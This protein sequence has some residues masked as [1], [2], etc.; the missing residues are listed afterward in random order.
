MYWNKQ[1]LQQQ[2]KPIFSLSLAIKI[3]CQ[4]LFNFH[5][6][7][8]INVV[9]PLKLKSNSA[10]EALTRLI[11]NLTFSIPNIAIPPVKVPLLGM[12]N[13]SLDHFSCTDTTI[14]TIELL[15]KKIHK[16]IS[17]L[18]NF[19]YLVLGLLVKANGHIRKKN[20]HI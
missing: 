17:I 3:V 4:F 5:A 6:F 11:H 8:C 9:F 12:T 7:N 13:V 1:Y 20:G 15:D 18:L 10:G 19:L 14:T 16:I 2:R